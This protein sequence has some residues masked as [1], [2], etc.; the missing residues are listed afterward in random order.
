[1]VVQMKLRIL[2]TSH[3][4]Q[5][6][7]SRSEEELHWTTSEGYEVSFHSAS[8]SSAEPLPGYQAVI[9]GTDRIDERFLS[10]FPDLRAVVKFGVGIDNIDVTECTKRGVLV[11]R[12]PG[13]NTE[14]VAEFALALIMASARLIP[15]YDAVIKS[16]RWE[17]A[18]GYDV[19]GKTLGV[20]GTGAIG[21]TLA[22]FCSG[23]DMEIIGYDVMQ[24]PEFEASCRGRYA[25]LDDLLTAA[26][27][28]SIHVPLTVGTRGLIG[29]RELSM[30]KPTAFVINASRGGI[31]D[32]AALLEAL[33]EKR[34]AG[35]A[36][37]VFDHEPPVGSE[38]ALHP[39][40]IAAPH[41]AAYTYD[42]LEAMRRAACKVAAELATGADL[43]HAVN[44]EAAE[45]G[46]DS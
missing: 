45:R 11:G 20:V 15:E 40:V 1:M 5:A 7:I 9:T 37:D 2:V 24:S 35:A 25:C 10:R 29:A 43:S 28:V 4:F 26:D 16:G 3:S 6:G 18:V 39:R 46:H 32:E 34:I 12:L 13:V 27:F 14:A 33:N 19:H 36:L 31:V 44:P 23:L 17:R 38:L 42:T 21:R 41:V 30:M 8:L 22:R